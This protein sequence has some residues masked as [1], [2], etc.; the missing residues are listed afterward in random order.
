MGSTPTPRIPGPNVS[1]GI[2]LVLIAVIFFCIT[3]LLAKYLTRF[4]P[5]SLIVWARF[6]FHLL[7]VVLLLGPRYRSRL[8]KTKR[9]AE[10]VLRGLLLFL[11]AMLFISSL[12]FLPLAE[13]TAIAYLAPLFVTL[14]SVAFLKEKVELARWIA[15]LCSF[16]GVVI[17]IRPGSGV[18]TWAALL[19]IANAITFA[20]YQIVTRRIAGLESPYT[21]IFYAGLVGCVLLSA[22]L[23][24][25]WMLP[26]NSWHAVC[27]VTI[28]LL[29]AL[30]HLI[31]IKAYEYAPASRLAPFSYSQLIWVAIIGFFVFG[32]FPDGWSLLGMAILVASGIF[33][34]NQQRRQARLNAS[35]AS[36]TAN[37]FNT[38]DPSA[39]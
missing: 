34:A 14:M 10:Q 20:T 17:I 37:T 27:F 2:S 38:S 35:N 22:I 30:G 4:Y 9:L 28:G 11:G 5:V 31:L 32:D 7:L 18:F 29:G 3:D 23:P 25:I 16:G 8:V 39:D 21:S 26:Q 36:N 33:M 6:T 24:D 1:R 15:V 19:P 12:K 13:A